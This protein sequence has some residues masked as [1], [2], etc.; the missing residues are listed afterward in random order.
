MGWSSFFRTKQAT[1]Q[2]L[3]TDLHADSTFKPACEQLAGKNKYF[4]QATSN[5]EP[6]R[7][8]VDKTDRS[9]VV[10]TKTP[11]TA[12]PGPVHDVDRIEFRPLTASAYDAELLHPLQGH[13]HYQWLTDLQRGSS[14]FVQHALDTRTGK[15]V[16]IKFIS[17]GPAA[18]VFDERNVL[19][20]LLNHRLAGSHPN[21]VE[22]HEVF[23]T[24][25]HLAIVMSYCDGGDMSELVDSRQE[26]QGT[27]MSEADAAWFLQQLLCAVEFCHRLG[28]AVRDI[29]LDNM[30]LQGRG[31]RPL[32]RICDFGFSKDEMGQSA[33][34]STCG[35]PEYMAP[36][37]LFE[38]SY[39]GKLADVWSIGVSLSVM[40]T[41][42]FPFA[43]PCDAN[44]P[45]VVR[46]QRMFAR[47]I[48]GDAVPVPHLSA[49]CK[50]LLQGMLRPDPNERATMEQLAGHPW[51][52]IAQPY[53]PPMIVNERLIAAMS[54]RRGAE[55]AQTIFPRQSA[56]DIKKLVRECALARHIRKSD[57]LLRQ[58]LDSVAA[59]SASTP[60]QWQ[61]DRDG[62]GDIDYSTTP[63][64]TSDRGPA[65]QSP[66][67]VVPWRN[68]PA[69]LVEG[70]AG[71]S[72]TMHISDRFV[73]N[74]NIGGCRSDRQTEG[75][76]PSTQS[77]L[78]RVHPHG[79]CSLSNNSGIAT[80]QLPLQQTRSEQPACGQSPRRLP[81]GIRGSNS[82]DVLT[83]QLSAIASSRTQPWQGAAQPHFAAMQQTA[84]CA[85]W[86]GSTDSVAQL[87]QPRP[88]SAQGGRH[89]H[90]LRTRL[91]AASL[92]LATAGIHAAHSA[93]TLQ[94]QSCSRDNGWL[95]S[96]VSPPRLAVL[97]EQRQSQ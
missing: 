67:A 14:G 53:L 23:V 8:P 41:G 2:P 73:G 27:P 32:L 75:C 21:I 87:H 90:Y 28:I 15:E 63:E 10:H 55:D 70:V 97:Q 46:M 3:I 35:T 68:L 7:G 20:E 37:V 18:A 49:A 56:A 38:D 92:T 47:I 81:D 26:S 5:F 96:V 40:L 31:S 61:H 30:L 25:H 62:R 44:V 9:P 60:L 66:F 54:D 12:R 58:R 80:A 86:R 29:K 82:A 34:K 83:G 95:P 64:V 48:K 72:D 24:P 33:C 43:W 93:P 85:G 59:S 94:Q 52:S 51:L 13:P 71:N 1:K 77:G 19:R 17:C 89:G 6:D 76:W 45:K 22:L 65:V 74:S 88:G 57:I 79:I 4:V 16:A 39:D 78:C 84:C 91:S 36:E 69:S 11:P 50:D 42:E